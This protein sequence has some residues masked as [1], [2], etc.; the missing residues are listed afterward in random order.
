M[1]WRVIKDWLE[2]QL[3]LLETEMVTFEQIMLPYLQVDSSHTLYDV[4]QEQ[5]LALPAGREG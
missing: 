5:H 1:A 4:M 3:A 2:A